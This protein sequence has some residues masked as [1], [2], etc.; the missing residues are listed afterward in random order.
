[1]ENSETKSEKER[2]RPAVYY[3]VMVDGQI[4]SA[5]GRVTLNRILSKLDASRVKLIVRG[6]ECQ[7]IE[8]KTIAIRI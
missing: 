4:H 8:K 3:V 6:H 2:R 7:M 5:R 1:M